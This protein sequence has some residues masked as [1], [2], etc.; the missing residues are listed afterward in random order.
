MKTLKFLAFAAFAVCLAAC[1][2]D[3]GDGNSVTF[4]VEAELGQ[5]ADYIT[6]TDQEVVVTMSN[7]KKGDEEYRVITSSL[8]LQV[9]KSVATDYG[10]DLVVE[11]LDKNH[12][13]IGELSRYVIETSNDYE[14]GEF[15]TILHAG[16]VHAQMKDRD[17]LKKLSPEDQEELDK[18]FKEGA[19][20][21]VKPLWS[22]GRYVDYKEKSSNSEGIES[23]SDVVDDTDD[24]DDSDVEE[25]AESSSSSSE[26]FDAALDSYEKYV[27][28]YIALLKKASKGD[29][30]AMA[31]YPSLMQQA[32]ECGDK[33]SSAKG[34]L[35]A[36]QM[37][38]YTKIQMKML[39]A[40]QEMK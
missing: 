30:T 21:V 7:E 23:S 18:L 34:D 29:M 27:D 37:A 25:V 13:K 14:N 35:T 9:S 10:F 33:L 16:S 5:L 17:K 22:S 6:V 8:A 24:A 1:G 26:D 39:K 19:Y 12:V 31:E 36:S 20:I 32:Q 11:V 4:K 38:R 40:A 2:G 15:T 28:K 3:K